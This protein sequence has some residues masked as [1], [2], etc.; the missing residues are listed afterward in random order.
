MLPGLL[1]A[2]REGLE[3]ALVVGIVLGILHKLQRPDR[4]RIVWLG[5][6]SAIALS[7][8]I[9]LG[10]TSL[11]A[12][13]EGPTEGLFEG[14]TM[15]LAA[16][17]LTWMIFWMQRQGRN[18]RLGLETHMREAIAGDQTG[19]LFWVPFVAVLREGI[20]LALFLTA[21]VM[22]SSAQQAWTG[23]LIG[24]VLAVAVVWSIFASIIRL[25]LGRFFQATGGILLIFAAGLVARG[26]H[27]FIEIGWLPALV[28][29]IWNTAWALDDTSV[30]GQ[31]AKSLFGYSN[32]P[33]LSEVIAYVAY[34]L[35]VSVLLWRTNHV[36]SRALPEPKG[37]SS[38]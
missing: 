13:L 7:L 1:L 33:A 22:A 14:F 38:S 28:E 11:G 24:L 6:L 30:L 29:H 10:L 15:L 8:M 2:F 35:A 3:A 12:E 18:V 5:T 26:A 21:A 17:V 4:A 37:I 19:Q 9:A 31:I 23:G 32:S 34:L 25:N 16:V 27:A 36:S 20:E